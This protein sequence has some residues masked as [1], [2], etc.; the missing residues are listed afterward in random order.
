MPYISLNKDS[1][2]ILLNENAGF[3]TQLA[4]GELLFSFLEIDLTGY[5]KLY[6]I[7][8]SDNFSYDDFLFLQSQYPQTYKNIICRNAIPTIKNNDLANLQQLA[9]PFLLENQDDFHCLYNH[10]VF[11]YTNISLGAC[12]FQRDHNE[13]NFSYLQQYCE[14]L[15][16]SHSIYTVL[17]CTV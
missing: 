17:S 7:I 8:D 16:I 13:L 6:K 14:S 5:D 1:N 2:T 11:E 9:L 3:G 15:L 10:P 4:F 12:D